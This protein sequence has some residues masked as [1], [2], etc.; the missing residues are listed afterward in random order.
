M[1]KAF[2][3]IDENKQFSNELPG[4]FKDKGL[5][6]SGLNYHLVSVF[7]S[8][9]TGK[10][11]L[12]NAL[13]NTE[14]GVMDEKS[15][16]QTTKGIWMGTASQK[17]GKTSSDVIILDVEG[18]DGRERGED[19]D[20]ERKAALFALAS[21]EIL[22]VNMWE[23]QVGL[24]QGANMGLL[25]TVFEVNLSLFQA[26]N[27]KTPRSRI[28]FVIRD[29]LG[30]TPL[31]NLSQTLMN[32]LNKHW[33]SLS[34]PSEDLENSQISDFFDIDFTTLPH[35]VLLPEK[36]SEDI[37]QLR[38]RFIDESNQG[39][40]FNNEY[41][42][43][44]PLDGW[45][46]YASQIWEQIELNKDLDL[47]T[48]QILV[49]RFRCV[50]ISNQ[51]WN[52]FN[53]ELKELNL[54]LGTETLIENFGTPLR[55]IRQRALHTYDKLAS[56][57]TQTIYAENRFELLGKIDGLLTSYYRSQLS[58]IQAAALAEFWAMLANRKPD[59]PFIESL[60]AA[61]LVVEE[62]Y[63]TAAADA[64]IDKDFY[65]FTN[66]EALFL[67]VLSS[68]VA[69]ARK[70]EMV[71]LALKLGKQVKR[72]LSSQLPA[73]LTNPD[74]HT[75]DKVQLALDAAISTALIPYKNGADFHLGGNENENA[76]GKEAVER[77]AWAALDAQL[78]EFTRE[79][80]LNARLRER[81][82]DKFRYDANGLPVVWGQGDD[83]QGA[84][85]KA[86]D[87]AL[88]LL[89]ALSA[90]KLAD[91]TFLRRPE[92]LIVEDEDGIDYEVLI[93]PATSE[94][95]RI[96]FK[97]FADTAFVDAKR[98]VALSATHIPYYI[99]LIILV[100]GW[101]EFMMVL[102][103]PLLVVLLLILGTGAYFVV[104]MNLAG[105]VLSVADAMMQKVS[106]E[107]KKRAREY[108]LDHNQQ[109]D[110]QPPI[111]LSEMSAPRKET[112]QKP[113]VEIEID[114]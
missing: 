52:E 65:S 58:A 38:L 104:S 87:H 8:Q 91:D 17:A 42:R 82:E 32:D 95:V 9:S 70:E 18:T 23:S 71:R 49:A 78:R 10:S 57:Y 69:K 47:P 5:S 85:V 25:K 56:R 105:P 93:E 76:Q 60:L 100:L 19:Q 90:A 31:E 64:T 21:S 53:S 15:R 59:A 86:R 108:L 20:F 24:Y 97:R 111:E 33:Q 6:E 48:Q 103:N 16:G 3:V 29:Y 27:R 34:K 92:H 74:D 54:P 46:M 50:D 67:E 72:K 109:R 22:I 61:K 26:A 63:R 36:F 75:W 62:K 66:E 13:F 99:W 102:R 89:P 114:E 11:T 94:A 44:V 7:G 79:D 110:A 30:N 96:Q 28:L 12:L 113:A 35:K 1:G 2:Q 14:F 81:F 39:F 68:E 55:E 88:L 84:Y 107:A 77:A 51:A 83:I 40:L 4:Y 112:V 101:N 73:L 106:E 98:A 45:P 43:G 41:H 37:D 80:W